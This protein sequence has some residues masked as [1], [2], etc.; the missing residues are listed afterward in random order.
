MA[1]YTFAGG[2]QPYTGKELTKGLEIRTIL[3]GDILSFPLQQHIGNPSVPVVRIGERVLTGQCIAVAD[4]EVSARLHA[5]ISGTVLRIEPRM[6]ADGTTAD[7]ILIEN[8]H[9]YE[10]I[11]YPAPRR[12]E[13]LRKET[14]LS[15]IR[16]A[17]IVGMGGAGLPTHVKLQVPPGCRIDYIIVNGAECEPYETANYR[18]M[19]ENPAKIVNALRILHILFPRARGVI[20]V[21]EEYEACYNMLRRYTKEEPWILVKHARGKYPQG[22]ERQMIYAV[23]G[24]TLNAKMLPAEIGVLVLNV[25]TMAAINQAVMIQEPLL[26]RIITVSGDAVV[27]PR[28]FRV[29]IGTSYETLLQQAGG[30]RCKPALQVIGGLMQGQNVQ[31]L[32][33]PVTKCSS[34]LLC[35]SRDRAGEM[36]ES[37]CIRC[38]RCVSACPN[39]LVPVEIYRT[40]EKGQKKD[41]IARGGLECNDCGCCAYVCPANRPLSAGIG[42]MRREIL[43]DAELAGDYAKRYI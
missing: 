30:L 16:D 37:A 10:E 5:S 27:S 12:M 24:R 35:L 29:R 26:T 28:N 25:D 36:K 14:I 2:I 23:T 17:G 11:E 8:D 9:R 6:L 43:Q 21:N 40:V 39:R 32:D 42:S 34:S 3:P 7:C 33:V 41:F 19:L 1:K 22:S 20:A 13:G 31:N 15:A 18:R 38:G 4:G